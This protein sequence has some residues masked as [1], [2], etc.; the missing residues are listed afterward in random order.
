MYPDGIGRR[1][2]AGTLDH[3]VERAQ[4]PIAARKTRLFGASRCGDLFELIEIFPIQRIANSDEERARRLRVQFG[5]IVVRDRS[6]DRLRRGQ[7][8]KG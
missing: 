1:E 7:K 5:L 8:T 3:Q 4:P 2:T 6:G